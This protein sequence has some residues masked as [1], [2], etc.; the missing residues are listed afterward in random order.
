MEFHLEM[1]VK[2]LTNHKL[3]KYWKGFEAVSFAFYNKDNVYLYNH[4][5]FKTVGY[6]PHLLPWSNEFSG[7]TIILYEDHPTAIV[8]LE[9]HEEFEDLY[10]I[11][12]HELFHGYQFLMGDERYADEL[13]MITYP[14][15][16]ENMELRIQ[17]RH[18]LYLSVMAA[19]IE[20][21]NHAM[22]RFIAIRQQR[23]QLLGEY[24]LNE[25]LI[26]TL[27]GPA[28]YVELNAYAEK[29]TLP[30]E[31][32]LQKFSSYLIDELESSANIRRSCYGSGLFIC[33]LLDELRTD[34]KEEFMKS[35]LSLYAFFKQ[36][37][38]QVIIPFEEIS[39]S[40]ETEDI[41]QSVKTIREKEFIDFISLEGYHLYIEGDIKSTGFNPM[42]IIG[43]DEKCIHK[44]NLRIQINDAE[45]FL[46]KPVISYYK[47]DLRNINK[48]HLVLD[49]PPTFNKDSLILNGIGE[50][51]GQY[52]V[53]ED[54][55]WLQC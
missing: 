3:Q 53:K 47:A 16:L 6:H 11:C 49:E 29:S 23:E 28:W 8:N 31:E 55:C 48:L 45:Y 10:A 18:H 54:G 50:I 22:Y 21:R 26:E 1:I 37:V 20:E 25:Y 19:T 35:E 43:G 4:P 34:W 42:G 14:L 39:I 46:E 27:E 32:V 40:K 38:D 36:F 2:C 52:E 30:N 17:E 5:K 33:L 15:S 41:M 9:L 24:V 12:V 44:N 13:L 7:D 51:K